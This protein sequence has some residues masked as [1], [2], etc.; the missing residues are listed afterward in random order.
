MLETEN[1]RPTDILSNSSN[2]PKQGGLESSSPLAPLILPS[3]DNTSITIELK[4]I[5]AG[6]ESEEG[7]FIKI[8]TSKQGARPQPEFVKLSNLVELLAKHP[9]PIKIEL[10]IFKGTDNNN[11]ASETQPRQSFKTSFIF[12]FRQITRPIITGGNEKNHGVLVFSGK[13][14][15]FG[16]PSGK[17]TNFKP[18]SAT[19]PERSG[20]TDTQA[21]VHKN[22]QT[23]R[24]SFAVKEALDSLNST[25]V[26]RKLS[27]ID[28]GAGVKEL[29]A[30]SHTNRNARPAPETAG[31]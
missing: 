3:A 31:R 14:T 15:D 5:A 26:S 24:Q 22:Y 10:P 27:N 4:Q 1:I 12:D 30:E 16:K 13:A 28:F 11:H 19:I 9:D 7:S 2:A 23:D 25:V 8:E 21:S 17:N 20:S 18:I 29:S 6:M